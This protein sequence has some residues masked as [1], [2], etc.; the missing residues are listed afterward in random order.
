[1]TTPS[2]SLSL[3]SLL[4]YEPFVRKVLRNMVEGEDQLND[5]VQETWVRVLRRPPADRNGVRGWLATV[6]RNLARD[7]KRGNSRRLE[8]EKVV[9]RP[10]VDTSAQTSSERLELHQHL[11]Q[12]VLSLEEP[13]KSVVVLCYYEGMTPAQVAVKLDRKE[14]TVRSQLHRA[15]LLLK[16]RLDGSFGDRRAWMAIGVPWI[17]CKEGRS[18]LSVPTASSVGTGTWLALSAAGLGGLLLWSPWN[19][20]GAGDA[21]ATNMSAL[22]SPGSDSFGMQRAPENLWTPSEWPEEVRKLASG[23]SSAVDPGS[24]LE[25]RVTLNGEPVSNAQVWGI[26]PIMRG[27]TGFASSAAHA[28]LS[29]LHN[30]PARLATLARKSSHVGITSEAGLVRFP[31]SDGNLVLFAQSANCF[32]VLALRDVRSKVQ[33]TET[34]EF[35]VNLDRGARVRVTDEYGEPLSGIPIELL[36][37]L[38]D[39]AWRTIDV[40]ETTGSLGEAHF[41]GFKNLIAAE[42]YAVRPSVIGLDN[43]VSVLDPS[44]VAGPI[45]IQLPAH[46]ILEWTIGERNPDREATIGSVW[47]QG[48]GADGKPIGNQGWQRIL[49]ESG[50]WPCVAVG[51]DLL[52]R[53]ESTN[54]GLNLEWRGQGPGRAGER[55]IAD[56][57]PPAACV[58]EGRLMAATGTEVSARLSHNLELMDE[59]QRVVR[60]VEFLPDD[61]G[62]FRVML[63]ILEDAPKH[64]DAEIVGMWSSRDGLRRVRIGLGPKEWNAAGSL[65]LGEIATQWVPYAITGRLEDAA[66]APLEGITLSASQERFG[67]PVTATTRK[68]GSFALVG[69]WGGE[70]EVEIVMT[71]G[72]AYYL[73]QPVVWEN[74]VEPMVIQPLAAGSITGLFDGGLTVNGVVLYCRGE[75][76]LAGFQVEVPVETAT[77]EFRLDGLLPGSYSLWIEGSGVKG[78][79]LMSVT[80][81]PGQVSSAGTLFSR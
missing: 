42:S 75:G 37:I 66:G 29:L 53:L 8:R 46:G 35:P 58:V 60:S 2:D 22:Q 80:V 64:L 81:L 17:L 74:Q 52:V 56:L 12:A 31:V 38:P 20:P 40:K 76:D 27:A 10:E 7:A 26:T 73:D 6:A 78:K 43:P 21:S 70:A 45:Q 48:I 65:Q 25:F 79:K 63:P 39:G 41:F 9:A 77:G 19:S 71:A 18:S 59:T 30:Y 13:Y 62:Y 34:L 14:S 67:P 50:V 55:V 69:I 4:E 32:G 36:S 3:E 23:P 47:L 5:L 49:G 28:D 16:E 15:H 57:L 51:V 11:V 24:S 1:M 68:D 44:P 33:K 61:S 72:Q 54:Q